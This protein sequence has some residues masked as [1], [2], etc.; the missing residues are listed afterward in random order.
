MDPAHSLL[1]S[2]VGRD[3][4]RSQ[5][6][7]GLGNLGSPGTGGAVAA[8]LMPWIDN[9]KASWPVRCAAAE[10]VGKLRYPAS[11]T[12]NMAPVA[13]AL[14]RQALAAYRQA[15]A[16]SKEEKIPFPA[17]VRQLRGVLASVQIGLDGAG[18]KQGP[19]ILGQVKG[20]DQERATKIL[21]NVKALAAKLA[22]QQFDERNGRDEEII[23]RLTKQIESAEAELAPLVEK[24][25]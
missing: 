12:P 17:I 6:A 8:A 13:N 11:G 24:A 4:A 21:D 20:P 9:P 15:L 23:E 18:G 3:W 10:A 16:L 5:A 19:G 22:E 7:E 14:G 25:G 1:H 2:P